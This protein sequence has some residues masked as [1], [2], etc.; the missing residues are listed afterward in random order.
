MEND[1]LGKRK[2][3]TDEEPPLTK[4]ERKQLLDAAAKKIARRIGSSILEK[5]PGMDKVH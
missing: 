5:N 3:V 2:E 4:L 1:E